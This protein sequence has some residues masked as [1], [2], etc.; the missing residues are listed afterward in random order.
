MI[1]PRV[2]REVPQG[3]TPS[4][5]PMVQPPVRVVRPDVS[6]VV[7]KPPAAEAP[8]PPAAAAPPLST[9][10]SNAPAAASPPPAA[11]QTPEA[12]RKARAEEWRRVGVR[13]REAATLTAKAKV[14]LAEAARVR[15]WAESAKKDPAKALA[16]ILGVEPTEAYRL[17]QNQMLQ[18]KD[19]PAPV[20]LTAEQ[21]TAQRLEKIERE[22]AEE[23]KAR[24]AEG[25]TASRARYIEANIVPAISANLDK[26]EMIADRGPHDLAGYVYDLM[27]AH[28]L[29][30][31]VT[32]P[33][34]EVLDE[35]EVQ[36]TRLA[37][38]GLDKMARLK[39]FAGR[40]ATPARLPTAPASLAAMA[41]AAPPP[42]VTV[43]PV[44][45]PKR[46][47]RA[48]LSDARTPPPA[49]APAPPMGVG[50]RA[51]KATRQARALAKL[52]GLL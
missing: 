52:T 7:A 10:P 42:E 3:P 4:A 28:Y 2:T 37:E 41:A 35:M 47:A 31:G 51:D 12:K 11:E 32:L 46:R 27:N 14:D 6:P 19:E 34:T 45:Q 44:V 8:P 1:E 18:I 13:E 17:L 50:R 48:S 29:S 16:E 9:T 30:T 15:G 39:K 33:V 20:E 5:N 23:A 36:L 21:M 24:A 38:Q 49:V 25:E 40:F 22:R 26:Y 43:E